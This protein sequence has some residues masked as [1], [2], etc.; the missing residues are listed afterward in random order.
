MSF[1][2][3]SGD[4]KLFYE[5]NMFLDGGKVKWICF[6]P[7]KEKENGSSYEQLKIVVD[8]ILY[9]NNKINHLCFL[10]P[11]FVSSFLKFVSSFLKYNEWRNVFK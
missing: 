7:F 5:G 10:R 9:K 8:N 6:I 2:F 1:E 4:D 11:W 3:I